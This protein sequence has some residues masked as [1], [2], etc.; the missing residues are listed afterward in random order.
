MTKELY[1]DLCNLISDDIGDLEDKRDAA[2]NT[3]AMNRGNWE[4]PLFQEEARTAAECHAEMR[5]LKG[6]LDRFE[7]EVEDPA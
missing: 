3:M 5:R 1:V 6:I 7:A 2:I 4:H